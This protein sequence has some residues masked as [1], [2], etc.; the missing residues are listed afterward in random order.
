MH[1]RAIFFLTC[2]GIVAFAAIPHSRAAEKLIYNQGVGGSSQLNISSYLRGENRAIQ[3]YDIAKADL[4]DD[5]LF[6]FILRERSCVQKKEF[7]RFDI[8]AETSRGMV[9][10]GTIEARALALSEHRSHGVRDILAYN[11]ALNDYDYGLYVWVS[12]QSQ[13]ILSTDT[14]EGF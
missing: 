14:A 1:I 2:L 5:D 12:G 7:C 13:Y 6:E 9:S 8:L 4:N 11:N 10:L 3:H